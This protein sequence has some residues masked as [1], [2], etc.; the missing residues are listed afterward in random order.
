M[1]TIVPKI[2]TAF[3]TLFR[4]DMTTQWRNRRGLVISLFIP[5]M[6]VVLW[7]DLVKTAGGPW[8]LSNAL[9]YGLVAL[10]LM[11]YS[12][13]IARD[14]DKGVF[15]RLRVAPIP[16]WAIMCSR[17]LVQL[18]MIVI[19]TL[20]IFLVGYNV[21][22]ISLSIQG[23]VVTLFTSIIGAAFYLS[24]GQLIVALIK[25]PDT[26][27]ST[28]RFI[29]II[30]AVSGMILSLYDKSKKLPPE[31]ATIFHWTP[32]STINTMTATGMAPS[33]WDMH[34]T[35]AL[36]VTLGYIIV[37]LVIGVKKFTWESK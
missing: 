11:G 4:A 26:V 6:M 37:C 13:T 28:S 29:F 8:V 25:N 22:H 2:S 7:K 20:A 17:L 16:T 18:L 10:G 34:A 15:Q 12:N 33:T 23:Y 5:V 27:N 24:V 3:K 36:L 1:A 19:I 9:S 14:R 21:D 30:F 35:N 32:Y 31:Y